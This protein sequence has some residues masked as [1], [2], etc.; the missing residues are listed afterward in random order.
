MTTTTREHR[1]TIDDL[2]ALQASGVLDAR[3]QLMGGRLYDRMTP[4]PRHVTTVERLRRHL[5]DRLPPDVI[6]RQKA[7]VRLDDTS[8]PEPDLAIVR[9]SIDDYADHHPTPAD[10]VAVV[11]VSLSS[12]DADVSVKQPLYAAHG[13][14]CTIVDLEHNQVI[15]DEGRAVESVTIAGVSLDVAHLLAPS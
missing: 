2:Y 5:E 6:I 10:V 3:T 8:Y 11:E 14:A 4:S 12:L 1:W 9:G 15:D 13:I 7:P